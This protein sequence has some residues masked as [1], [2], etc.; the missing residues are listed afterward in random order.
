M[1]TDPESGFGQWSDRS[2]F[3]PQAIHSSGGERGRGSD[4]GSSIIA[5]TTTPTLE[6]WSIQ[7]YK[8]VVCGEAVVG[9]GLGTSIA[10]FVTTLT[11]TRTNESEIRLREA[12]TIAINEL[13][14]EAEA[15]GANAV[16]G[17][18]LDYEYCNGV[19]LVSASGTAV[20]VRELG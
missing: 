5:V 16:V 4:A 17:V 20:T 9:T 10:Q 15:A 18:D 12:R 7:E 2:S 8:E 3:E 11:G 13:R 6:G 1:T 14:A 19:I